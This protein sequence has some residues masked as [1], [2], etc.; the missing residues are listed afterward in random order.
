MIL[1]QYYLQCLSQ[2]SYLIGDETS[3]RAV[4][5]DPRRDIEEYLR[6]AARLEL[7]IELVLETHFHADFVSGHLTLSKATGAPIVFGPNANPSILEDVTSEVDTVQVFFSWFG[8][9]TLFQ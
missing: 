3:G 6:D 5:V 4:V 8:K 9:N 1:K 2:A 7:C